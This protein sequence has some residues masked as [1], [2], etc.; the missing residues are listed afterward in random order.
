MLCK[1]ILSFENT[2]STEYHSL[3]SINASDYAKCKA[4]LKELNK[5]C[6]DVLLIDI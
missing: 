3:Q 1:L 6:T 4:P 2:E 5:N